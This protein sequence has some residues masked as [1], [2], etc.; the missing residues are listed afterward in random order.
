ML[1]ILFKHVSKCIHNTAHWI[2][3]SVRYCF[4]TKKGKS[5]FNLLHNIKKNLCFPFSNIIA[6]QRISSTSLF[7]PISVYVHRRLQGPTWHLCLI[8]WI[9]DQVWP[10]N[11]LWFHKSCSHALPLKIRFV[12]EHRDKLHFHRWMWKQPSSVQIHTHIILNIQLEENNKNTFLNE[13]GLYLFS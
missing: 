1:L 7:N 2:L 12:N 13:R 6:G 10:P 3:I 11:Y 4:S 5:S 8:C 9:L